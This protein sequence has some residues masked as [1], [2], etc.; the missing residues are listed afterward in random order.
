MGFSSFNIYDDLLNLL[1]ILIIFKVFLS[2]LSKI[3]FWNQ[4]VN[5]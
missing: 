5:K 3:D 1:Y 4:I 2:I